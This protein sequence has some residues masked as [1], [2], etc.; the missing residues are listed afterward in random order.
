M[1][2]VDKIKRDIPIFEKNPELIYLDSCATTLKPRYVLDKM[3][4]YYREYGVNIHRGVYE[5]SFRATEEYDKARHKIARFINASFEEVVFTRGTTNS[6]NMIA[7][8]LGDEIIDEGDEI[9]TSELEH[10]SSLL[11]WMR[12]AKKKNAK[13]VY[14]PLNEEGRITVG[15]FKKVLTEK[16]KVVAINFVSNTMG[17]STPIKEIIRLA[18]EVGSIVIVDAAQAAPHYKIDVRDL[19]C[20]FLAFSAHKMLGPTGI[21]ILY[22]KKHY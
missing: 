6:L 11:P 3:E 2:D 20:D 22:G 13:L 8:S 1:L 9:I 10:H 5:L 7:Q 4:E 15:N 12:V 19:D 14:I 21:G 17:Y 18:H 16:T